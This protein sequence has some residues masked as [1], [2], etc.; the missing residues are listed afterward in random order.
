MRLG[1]SWRGIVGLGVGVW[2]VATVALVAWALAGQPLPWPSGLPLPLHA[3]V[4]GYVPGGV[5]ITVATRTQLKVG[6]VPA[7]DS[8]RAVGTYFLPGIVLLGLALL[9]EH[10]G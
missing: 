3:L 2:A 7:P 4:L 5:A 6:A 1:N 9:V 10:L 8:L